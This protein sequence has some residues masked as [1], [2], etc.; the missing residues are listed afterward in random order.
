MNAK[1]FFHKNNKLGCIYVV[2]G[3]RFFYT[4]ASAVRFAGGN[5]DKV[6]TVDRESV[7]KPKQPAKKAPAKT[8]QKNKSQ[9]GDK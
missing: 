6:E 9:G 7:M 1:D 2:D 3:S 4:Y 5:K 8:G